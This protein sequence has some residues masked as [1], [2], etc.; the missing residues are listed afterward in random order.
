[1]SFRNR[2]SMR[3]LGSG[4][5]VQRQGGRRASPCSLLRA[6]RSSRR[7]VL[8][9][10]VLSLLVLFMLVGT[11]F[12]MSSNQYR[13]AS[14]ASAKNDRLGSPPTKLL[15][16]ALM[17]VLRDTGEPDSAI[18]Y[19]SLLRDL[20][21]SDGFE[22]VVYS[23]TTMNLSTTAGQVTRYAAATA[24]TP[25]AQLGP[26][27]GQL[28]DV[29]V[30]ELAFRAVD[31]LEKALNSAAIAPTLPDARHILKL[32]PSVNGVPEMYNMP[33][34]K[35]YFNGC[36]L[37]ITA[38]PAAGQSTRIVDFEE[39]DLEPISN[40]PAGV[41]PIDGI[42]PKATSTATTPFQNKPTTRMFRFRV[43]AFPRADGSPLQ[44]DQT[45]VRSPEVSDLVGATFIVNGR[46]FNGTGAGFNELATAGGPR[47]TAVETVGIVP[48]SATPKTKWLYPEIALTP[49]ARYFFA[50]D[51][52]N[53]PTANS[54]KDVW[55]ARYLNPATGTYDP[56]N[57][58][59]LVHRRDRQSPAAVEVPNLR[60]PGR[61][62]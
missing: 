10:V 31:P 1:M 29:Y 35:G 7:G 8:L 6:P 19:H 58:M 42:D 22:A 61:R 38:G 28:I 27:Q 39:I 51:P 23:P 13:N 48:D 16:G 54:N 33:R 50:S 45:A 18:R 49:N 15:D 36:L 57:P 12:L 2:G 21:G 17:K 26:T 34:T 25:A 62:R 24:G 53:D 41:D 60:R 32:E 52:L 14:T 55:G 59:I 30:R 4:F 11:A 3:V 46:P 20:Y 5:R 37:T 47:L 9:L 43:M 56:L 40:P 44:I